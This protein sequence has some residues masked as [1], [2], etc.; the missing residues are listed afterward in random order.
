MHYV[1][2]F[3]KPSDF[4]QWYSVHP[5]LHRLLG[6]F[7]IKRDLVNPRPPS[8]FRARNVQEEL[9][10]AAALFQRNPGT[11]EKRFAV[12]IAKTDCD[13]AGVTADPS[14]GQTGIPYVDG[15][16][17]DLNGS[18]DQYIE[19]MR[20]VV[21]EIWRGE[22]RLTDGHHGPPNLGPDRDL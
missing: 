2:I 21:A 6:C 1:R 18:L 15:R 12:R 13:A 11:V 5:A 10:I 19:L 3:E 20:C 4:Q 7:D 17:S 8:V 22:D 14:P 9:E 16:H